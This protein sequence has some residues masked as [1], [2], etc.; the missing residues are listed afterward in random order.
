MQPNKMRQG[1]T[2]WAPF[3]YSFVL[4]AAGGL[5]CRA[6]KRSQGSR[7]IVR[8]LIGAADGKRGIVGIAQGKVKVY[9]D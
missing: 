6:R 2:N 8:S 1:F 4:F 7:A 9:V 3:G 5:W